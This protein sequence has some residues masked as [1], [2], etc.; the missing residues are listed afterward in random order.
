M[1]K[2]YATDGANVEGLLRIIQ[3]IAEQ[4]KQWQAKVGYE[5]IQ[6]MTP[7]IPDFSRR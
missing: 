7:C 1:G 4:F 3:S 6:D 2:K 5:R